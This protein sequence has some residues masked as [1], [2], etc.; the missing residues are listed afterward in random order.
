MHGVKV[1]LVTQ[2]AVALQ[3]RAAYSKIK[4]L[5]TRGSYQRLAIALHSLRH[6]EPRNLVERAGG[7][8]T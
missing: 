6:H 5:E 7:W 2:H 3:E 8:V 4:T 1:P